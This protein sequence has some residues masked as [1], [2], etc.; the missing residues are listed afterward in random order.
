MKTI[1]ADLKK[2]SNVNDNKFDNT[3]NTV[4]KAVFDRSKVVEIEDKTI[5]TVFDNS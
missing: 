3:D 4:D 5:S 2:Y 1:P